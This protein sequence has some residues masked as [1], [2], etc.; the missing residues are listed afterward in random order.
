MPLEC[1]EGALALLREEDFSKPEEL[2][3]LLPADPRPSHVRAM[4]GPKSLL[5]AEPT[6]YAHA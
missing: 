5:L 3:F 2:Q 6:I 4:L 1:V